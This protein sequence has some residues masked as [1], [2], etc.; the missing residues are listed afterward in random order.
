LL[1]SQANAAAVLLP[2]DRRVAEAAAAAAALEA[3]RLAA[4]QERLRLAGAEEVCRLR[5][6]PKEGCRGG[7]GVRVPVLV[8]TGFRGAC[9][10]QVWDV[11]FPDKRFPPARSAKFPLALATAA[12][13]ATAGSHGADASSGAGGALPQRLLQ[14]WGGSASDEPPAGASLA[15]HAATKD[16]GQWAKFKG[17]KQYLV[18]KLL[19][20]YSAVSTHDL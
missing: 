20:T 11:R 18:C 5:L 2:S 6:A 10:P 9:W 14:A 19:A 8:P 3:A 15:T 16:G 1:R 13:A 12:A 4:F 7:N 17:T